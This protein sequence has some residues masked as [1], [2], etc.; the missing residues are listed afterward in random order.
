M[1]STCSKYCLHF[2]FFLQEFDGSSKSHCAEIFP[3]F[4][5]MMISSVDVGM[6]DEPYKIVRTCFMC[7]SNFLR[8]IVDGE[9]F[10]PCPMVWH[11]ATIPSF[12]AYLWNFFMLKGT[13]LTTCVMRA[14]NLFHVI[15]DRRFHYILHVL[16]D[17]IIFLLI[18]EF[19]YQVPLAA[20]VDLLRVCLFKLPW[21]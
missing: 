4:G 9:F 5:K 11:L 15:V 13:F 17:P 2:Y 10:A 20:C 16:F 21:G 18:Y 12:F 7:I 6:M 1:S 14:C 8:A 3:R 19:L